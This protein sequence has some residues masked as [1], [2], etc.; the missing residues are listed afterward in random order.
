MHK[1]GAFAT[2]PQTYRVPLRIQG[3]ANQAMV[4]TGFTQSTIRQGALLEAFPDNFNCTL[5]NN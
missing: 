4:D 2:G 5:E 1:A 3:G